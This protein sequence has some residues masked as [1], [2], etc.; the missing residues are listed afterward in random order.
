V[1]LALVA[2][3]SKH[4]RGEVFVELGVETFGPEV[5][6]NC[7]GLHDATLIDIDKVERV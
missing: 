1:P 6:E 3:V 5:E 2:T 4:H 7:P